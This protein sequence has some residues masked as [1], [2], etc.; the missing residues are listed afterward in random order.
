MTIDEVIERNRERAEKINE[1]ANEQKGL[2]YGF[3]LLYKEHAEEYEQ[4][5]E[6]LEDYKKLKSIDEDLRL[7]YCYEDL[8]D[9]DNWGYV[10]GYNEA[11]DDCIKKIIDTPSK[12][13][14]HLK[15]P[16]RVD[17]CLTMLADR[18]N[19]IIDLLV[20]LKECAE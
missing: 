9:A 2:N 3:Y 7:K 6:W 11:I 20:Q 4:I 10:R 15:E 1:K 12:I 14:T 18:Q 13:G 19:E 16:Q 8:S 5:I 17:T